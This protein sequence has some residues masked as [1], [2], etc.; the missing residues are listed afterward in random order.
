VRPS[1]LCGIA[2]QTPIPLHFYVEAFLYIPEDLKPSKKGR[3]KKNPSHIVSSCRSWGL[4]MVLVVSW[5]KHSAPGMDIPGK[6]ERP[7]LSQFCFSP[8][9]I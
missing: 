6:G 9:Q 8:F 7:A 4:K 1:R 5:W 2:S 3:K